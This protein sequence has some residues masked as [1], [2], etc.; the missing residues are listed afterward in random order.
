MNSGQMGQVSGGGWVNFTPVV[1]IYYRYQGLVDEF[2]TK[3]V[4]VSLIV[5][6]RR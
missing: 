4:E 2:D 3:L 5:E 6:T 1:T